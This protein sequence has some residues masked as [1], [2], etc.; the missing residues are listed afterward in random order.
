MKYSPSIAA[1]MPTG[2]LYSFFTAVSSYRRT[3]PYFIESATCVREKEGR[4]EGAKNRVD[5][6]R[7]GPWGAYCTYMSFTMEYLIERHCS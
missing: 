1:P 7:V 4:R 5:G 2:S 6:R 3:C